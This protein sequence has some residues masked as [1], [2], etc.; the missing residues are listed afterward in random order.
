[1]VEV[2]PVER[3]A[4][5][6]R[7]QVAPSAR[8]AHPREDHLLPLM[9]AVGAAGEDAGARIFHQRDFMGAITVSSYRFGDPVIPS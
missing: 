9:L 5:L 8:A 2:S 7:W 1:L 6:L 4:R 3:R